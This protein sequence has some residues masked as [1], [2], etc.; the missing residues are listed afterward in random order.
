MR[1]MRA[2]GASE[3]MAMALAAMAL[4]PD[5]VHERVGGN[6]RRRATGSAYSR[7][8]A[9][10]G[11]QGNLREPV[12]LGRTRRMCPTC[13]KVNITIPS[14]DEFPYCADHAIGPYRR[15]MAELVISAMA[16]RPFKRAIWDRIDV[17]DKEA[18]TSPNPYITG[19]APEWS[20]EQRKA[21]EASILDIINKGGK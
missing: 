12:Q 3:E 8:W 16:G 13:A 19:N 14:C 7:N 18:K 2:N 20:M 10:K 4:I 17:L 5:H 1:A 11:M 15:K 9:H 21:A 6:I